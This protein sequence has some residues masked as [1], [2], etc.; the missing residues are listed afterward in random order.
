MGRPAA[1][2]RRR[3]PADGLLDEYRA[4]L[5]AGNP[6]TTADIASYFTR[7]CD[8]IVAD[9]PACSSATLVELVTIILAT[10]I[11]RLVIN[12][13]PQDRP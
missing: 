9:D 8:D 10:A 3:R 6:W 4:A 7:R 1:A 11:Q 12:D 2:G 5:A 13:D